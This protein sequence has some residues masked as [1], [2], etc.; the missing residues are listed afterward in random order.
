VYNGDTGSELRRGKV[1]NFQISGWLD[2]N[3]DKAQQSWRGNEALRTIREV[4]QRSTHAADTGFDTTDSV[5][6]NSD[7]GR[8]KPRQNSE[9]FASILD[10]TTKNY[11]KLTKE[12]LKAVINP[13][14]S[15]RPITP[16]RFEGWNLSR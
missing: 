14:K 16:D 4:M 12:D 6:T 13:E 2:T 7:P 9:S 10:E 3:I 15:N 1:L 8:T 11:K 5:I